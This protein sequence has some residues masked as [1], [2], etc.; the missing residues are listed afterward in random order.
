MT[1]LNL[2]VNEFI[3]VIS[4]RMVVSLQFPAMNPVM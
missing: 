2:N 1:N 3:Y 4:W